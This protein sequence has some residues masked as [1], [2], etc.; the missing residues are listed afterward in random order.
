MEQNQTLVARRK[1]WLVLIDRTSPSGVQWRAR[2][3]A[4]DRVA[5]RFSAFQTG[6]RRVPGIPVGTAHVP[7]IVERQRGTILYPET[8]ICA[9]DRVRP[10]W[11][12]SLAGYR[13]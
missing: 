6:R 12:L 1:R 11:P 3:A 4:L 5:R 10:A 8:G 7:G 13:R 2:A 9:G